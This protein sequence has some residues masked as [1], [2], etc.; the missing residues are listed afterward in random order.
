M[1]GTQENALKMRY[2]TLKVYISF[3]AQQYSTTYSGCA[4]GK[5]TKYR[6]KR[7]EKLNIFLANFNKTDVDVVDGIEV[8][9]K[10][11]AG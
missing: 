9:V 6:E 1:S 7:A 8:I 2:V 4:S 5:I 3:V 10:N 11:R